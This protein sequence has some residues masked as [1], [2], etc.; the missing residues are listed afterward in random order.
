[1]KILMLPGHNRPMFYR[2]LYKKLSDLYAHYLGSFSV[3]GAVFVILCIRKT[4]WR[5]ITKLGLSKF[6]YVERVV[7]CIIDLG[8][9]E[10]G[11]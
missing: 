5:T 8:R 10:T 3:I 11:W 4:S 9:R 2:R 1:M 7:L 6:R